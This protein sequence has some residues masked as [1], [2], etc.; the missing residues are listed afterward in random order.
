MIWVDA[1]VLLI[2]DVIEDRHKSR[3][4]L[5]KGKLGNLPSEMRPF[6]GSQCGTNNLAG[7]K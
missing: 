2:Q 5:K 7:K 4:F 3:I 6:D 1:L